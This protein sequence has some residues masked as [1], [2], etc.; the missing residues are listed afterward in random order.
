MMRSLVRNL[1]FIN[2]CVIF[3]SCG[4]KRQVGEDCAGDSLGFREKV[5]KKASGGE[6]EDLLEDDSGGCHVSES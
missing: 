6:L 2:L 1:L 4:E 5:E 3:F